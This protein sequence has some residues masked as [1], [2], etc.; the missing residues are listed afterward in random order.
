MTYS[1]TTWV[2]DATDLTAA[3]MN[4]IENGIVAAEPRVRASTGFSTS[5]LA[6]LATETGTVSLAIGFRVLKLATNRPARVRLY[7]TAGKRDADL[8]RAIGVDPVGDHGLIL[9][10]VTTATLLSLDLSPEAIGVSLETVPVVT[11]PF[12]VQNRDVTP[13]VVTTTLGWQRVE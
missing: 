10:I 6:V 2:D 9:E 3:V 7:T 8:S 13:G 4:N 12:S 1:P 5:S 11:V